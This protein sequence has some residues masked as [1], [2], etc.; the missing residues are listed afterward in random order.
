MTVIGIFGPT[1]SGKSR[2]RRGGGRADSGRARLGRRDAGLSGP[3]DPHEPVC[4]PGPARRHLAARAGGL[5]RGVRAARPRGNRRRSSRRAGRRSSS[6]GRGST[7]GPRSRSW[8]CRPRPRRA[9]RERWSRPTTRRSPA[10]AHARLAELDPR[11]AAAVHP[12]DRRRVIRALELAEA[13]S[14]LAP[15]RD[16]LWRGDPAPDGRRRPRRAEGRARPPDRRAHARHVRGRRRRR[17]CGRRSPRRSRRP[18]ARRWASTRSRT[19]RRKRRS[20]RSIVRTRRYAAYQR[21]WMRR[22]PGLVIVDADRPPGEIA[23]DIVALAR[24]R[25]RLPDQLRTAS[26]RPSAFATRRPARTA[27]SRSC[28]PTTTT[29]EIV[30]WNP[31]GSTAEMSG[32]GTRIAGA[33]LMARTGVD[34]VRVVVGPRVVT[35]RAIGDGLFESEHGGGGGR[36]ARDGRRHRAD[37]R[38]RRQ[39]ARG[40]GR[41]S[42]RRHAA[43]PAARDTP[44]LSEPNERPGRARRRPGRGDRARVGARCGGDDSVRLERGRGRRRDARRRATCSCTSRAATCASGSRTAA[45][46]SRGRPSRSPVKRRSRTRAARRSGSSSDPSARFACR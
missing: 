22:V 23:D 28:V 31:D 9:S 21:K 27:S 39:S 12:N 38:R 2:G 17:R 3:A 24:T 34:D 5:G 42:R 8:S 18:R 25:E 46:G 13:G 14:S 35:V 40:R 45:R 10:A 7:S 29:S 11:A 37:P 20:A 1:A 33:W 32:N 16:R 43:R 15:S 30:I 26:S 44:A 6:A 4:L 41:R 19:S 36:R